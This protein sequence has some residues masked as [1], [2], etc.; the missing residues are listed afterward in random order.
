MVVSAL[1]MF[2][3]LTY[4]GLAMARQ[5]I[6]SYVASLVGTVFWF[7]LIMIPSALYSGDPR[8][9]LVLYLP[10]Y[11][12]MAL[13]MASTSD[14]V[15]F[16]RWYVYD[17]LTD[18]F[19]EAG[20]GVYHYVVSCFVVDVLFVFA[21]F[22]VLASVT[23]HYAGLDACWFLGLNPAFIPLVVLASL[24]TQVF[25]G[26]LTSV[27]YTNTRFGGGFHGFLQMVVAASTY[28]PL[29]R[30]P[31]P[32]LGLVNPT[33][34]LA[35]VLRASYGYSSITSSLLVPMS[36]ALAVLHFLAGY[37]LFRVADRTIAR[38]GV[39]FRV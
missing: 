6:T 14:S 38:Y 25:F 33:L 12:A 2:L 34:V 5:H 7:L 11:F 3:R 16:L 17:G 13:A 35:E 18:V 22:A 31:N 37:T 19:R 28:I 26:G 23:G 29:W 1:K 39:E 15:E 27:I 4:V 24:A 32:L 21:S 10:S 30:L 20:L 9:L 36:S 8:S